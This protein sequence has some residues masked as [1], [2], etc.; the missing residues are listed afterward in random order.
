M[1]YI[2]IPL[3]RRNILGYDNDTELKN[4]R[5]KRDDPKA[6]FCPIFVLDDIAKDAGVVFENMTLLVQYYIK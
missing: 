6:R 3:N 2:F 5:W 1:K 4:C